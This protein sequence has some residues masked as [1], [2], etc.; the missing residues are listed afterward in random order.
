MKAIRLSIHARARMEQRGATE[1]EVIETIRTAP[2]HDAERG[3]HECRK[4]FP[5][6]REWN[7]KVYASKQI[8]PIFAEEAREILVVT[9]YVYYA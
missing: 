9:V 3:R 8:R 1:E 2:W 5:F 4:G 7:G 6:N